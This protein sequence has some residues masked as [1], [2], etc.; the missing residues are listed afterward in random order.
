MIATFKVT[1]SFYVVKQFGHFLN[2]NIWTGSLKAKKPLCFNQPKTI[3][4]LSVF[5][6][7]FGFFSSTNV[8]TL[9]KQ[10]NAASILEFSTNSSAKEIYCILIVFSIKI[11]GTSQRERSDFF[12]WLPG[13]RCIDFYG[14]YQFLRTL[15]I[16]SRGLENRAFSSL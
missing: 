6:G 9:S 1:Y 16:V 14:Q 4:I 2:C 15:Y 8:I 11:R 13:Q 5:T 12:S 7:L 3:T 10:E